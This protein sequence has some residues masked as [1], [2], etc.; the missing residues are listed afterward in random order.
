GKQRIPHLMG[1]IDDYRV[2]GA[3][4]LQQKFCDPH[5]YDAPAVERAL[6]EKGVPLLSLEYDVVMP[7]GQFRTRIEAFLEMLAVE[8]L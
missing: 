7:V 8:D 5:A 2:K 1:L 6:K 3:I 4:F